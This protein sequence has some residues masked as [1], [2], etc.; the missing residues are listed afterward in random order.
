MKIDIK[1][2][3]KAKHKNIIKVFHPTFRNTQWVKKPND[4]P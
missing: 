3:P 2:K 1:G 4:P